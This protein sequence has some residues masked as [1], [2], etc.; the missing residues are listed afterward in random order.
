VGFPRGTK[1]L[2]PL[3]P[4]KV[5]VIPVDWADRPGEGKPSTL[6]MAPVQKFVDYYNDVS[7]GKMKLEVNFP[8]RWFRL[9]GKMM[10]YEVTELDYQNP[11]SEKTKAQKNRLFHNGVEVADPLV[12]FSNTAIVVF[13]LPEDQ[14]AIELTLQGFWNGDLPAPAQSDEGLL[15]NFFTAGKAFPNREIWSYYAH[16]FGHTIM[17]PD[18]YLQIANYGRD[19]LVQIPVGPFSGFEMMSTQ[20]GPSRTLS[21]WSRFL[22][23]WV[24][25]SNIYCA[26]LQTLR[27]TSLVLEP[28]DVSSEN[29]KGAIIR[30]SDNKAVVVESR[31]E[32]RYDEKHLRSRNGVIVY[33]VDT[34]VNH[35]EGPLALVPPSGR[36]LYVPYESGGQRQLDAMLYVGNSVTVEGLEITVNSSSTRDVVSIRKLSSN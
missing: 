5:T 6:H 34:S 16:E 2:D 29:L 9:P 19:D 1:N 36:G 13:V 20:G 14:S 7:Y 30:I 4:Y 23:N 25:E 3:K 28:I 21:L 24:S 8:D 32:T 17:L 26:D 27:D 35:G 18:Y 15:K 11:Y 33:T 10:D 12:D 22:M 31:R